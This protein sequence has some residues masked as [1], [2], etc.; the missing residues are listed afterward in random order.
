MVIVEAEVSQNLKEESNRILEKLGINM[1]AYI[2]MAL[3]QLVIQGGIPFTEKLNSS[4]TDEEKI[5]EVSAT[6]SIED[7]QLDEKDIEILEAIKSGKISFD[8]AR[9]E[10]MKEI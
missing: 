10:I 2:K 3:N 4:Y 1:S 5:S 6:L 9:T 7:M 8:E